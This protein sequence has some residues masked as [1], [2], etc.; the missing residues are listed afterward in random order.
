MNG[1]SRL[2][3][4]LAYLPII[5]W[6]YVLFLQR[7]NS[8]AVF[9]LK[10]SITLFLFLV[11]ALVIW[12]VAAWILAWIPYMVVVSAALFALVIAAYFY[13]VVA[14]VLG[15]INALR[16]QMDPLPGVGR[17]AERLPIQ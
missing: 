5:G 10:Q 1:S 8:L 7:K 14:W 15:V 9:H 11:A 2:P 6:L 16:N 4:V 12:A 3:A 13:G 17:W